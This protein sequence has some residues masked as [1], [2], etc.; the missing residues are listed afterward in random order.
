MKVLGINHDMY[1]SSAAI[2]IDGEVVAACAEERLNREKR[3]RVFHLIRLS[4]A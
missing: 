2:V 1:I 3:S 4:I